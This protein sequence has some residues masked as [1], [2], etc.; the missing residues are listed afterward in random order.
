MHPLYITL[1][2]TFVYHQSSLLNHFNLHKNSLTQGDTDGT[3]NKLF[4]F[5]KTLKPSKSSQ[6]HK[7]PQEVSRTLKMRLAVAIK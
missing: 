2:F 3:D 5:K 6:S 4:D 1:K 7:I